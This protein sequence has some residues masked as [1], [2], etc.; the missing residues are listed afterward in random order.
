MRPLHCHRPRPAL[1]RF[2]QL[3]FWVSLAVL[4][5]L[6]G[7]GVLRAD[8]A[9]SGGASAPGETRSAPGV[10]GPDAAIPAVA[11][12]RAESAGELLPLV[13]GRSAF[14]NTTARLKRVYVS[15]PLVLDSYT[16]NPT[17]IVITAKASGTS[18]LVLWDEAGRSQAYLIVS[19]LDMAGLRAGL[20]NAFPGDQIAVEAEED[21]VSLSGRVR[22]QAEMDAALKMAATYSKNVVNG[23]LLAP[24]HGSQVRL[25]VRIV[26]IDRSRLEQFGLNFFGGP[27]NPSGV[28]TGQFPVSTSTT[29]SSGTPGTLGETTL[30]V[31]DPLN[32]FLFNNNLSVGVTIKD[33]E[34]KR[35][36][37]IL[38][39]PTITT[40]SGEKASFLSGGEFPFPIIEGGAG[41]LASVTI[42]FRPYGVK[43]DFTPLVNED[44]TI[45]LKVAPEVSALDYTNA[46]TISGYTIPALSTRRAETEVELRDGQSFAISGLLDH[47]TTDVLSRVPVAGSLPVLGALF[48][49]KD[50]NHSVVELVVIVTPS[51]IDPLN[52]HSNQLD[53]AEPKFV[54]PL[55]DDKKFDQRL[56][57]AV[58]PF[59]AEAPPR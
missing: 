16:A 57:G 7:G 8:A 23:M 12:S 31:S 11:L 50:I 2:R 29:G 32:L 19:S 47:R 18:S 5:A 21:D 30:S 54:M 1:F 25:K 38:A 44:G 33:L 40:M 35:I 17:Q 34:S 26:E 52:D 13:V 28:T 51:I 46:V 24:S 36:L 43:L 27:K 6:C 49:S 39:E 48:R 10:A 3:E 14:L 20:R 15:N 59:P 56:R 9:L 58:P 37:Q 45:L 55:I 4:F 53:P 22:S 42:Q 41:A